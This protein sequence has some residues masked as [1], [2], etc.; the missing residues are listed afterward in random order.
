MT[1]TRLPRGFNA[2]VAA[3]VG[4]ELG[5]GVLGFALTWLASGFGA[6][7]AAAVLTLTVAPSV[8]L[9]LVGGAVADRFGPRR[10]M[11]TGTG[12]LLVSSAAAAVVAATWG[13]TVPLLVCLGCLIGTISAFLRPAVGVFPRLFV[14]GS[15]LGAAMAR[16]GV[17]SQ[18]AR[19]AAPPLGGL[20]VGM[21]ALSGVALL[22]VLGCMAMLVTLLLVQPPFSPPPARD[23]ATIRGIAAGLT[24][25]RATGGVPTL[26]WAVAIVAGAVIPTVVLG[27]PLT[28]RERGW[29]AVEAG[30][31]EAGWIA[32]GLLVGAWF[33]WRGTATKAWRPMMVGPLVIAVGLAV[34]AVATS[35]QLA[36]GAT[37]LVG[38]GVVIFTAHLFPTYVSLAPEPM[39]SRFQSLLILVQQAPQLV[40]NPVIGV[41]VASVGT[42][43]MITAAA[44][45]SVASAAVVASDRTVRAFVSE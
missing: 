13:V 36:A 2:W 11:V 8:V 9:G 4:S 35:W 43:P 1:R 14:E 28:A 27:I 20:L 31:I 25:A 42:G 10:V 29:S 45:L 34:L 33:A 18:I 24:V 22:D 40:M 3:S 37:W 30:I 41:T 26:L 17:A 38:V 23:A 15:S 7:V 5:A 44:L 21:I 32:G 16:A 12:A 39:V 6:H 19:T